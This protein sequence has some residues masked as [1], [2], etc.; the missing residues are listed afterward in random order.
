MTAF[1]EGIFLQRCMACI[2]NS[3]YKLCVLLWSNRYANKGRDTD[4]CNYTLCM[5]TSEKLAVVSGLSIL[6]TVK[7]SL[8]LYGY[9]HPSATVFSSTVTSALITE[10]TAN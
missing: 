1:V 6:D 7:I 9:R 4:F 5:Y 8:Y 10:I 3:V 2:L